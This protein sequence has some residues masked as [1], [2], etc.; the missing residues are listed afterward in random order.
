MRQG[1]RCG[2]WAFSPS[3]CPSLHF[4]FHCLTNF[5][6][7]YV[8]VPVRERVYVCVGVKTGMHMLMSGG[9]EHVSVCVIAAWGEEWTTA[10]DD[11]SHSGK[12]L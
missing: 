11:H 8:C 9:T 1:Y 6:M 2:A 7:M 4:A 10:A 12:P 5:M 3:V